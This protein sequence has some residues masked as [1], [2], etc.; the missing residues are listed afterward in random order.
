MVYLRKRR[1]KQAPEAGI[2]PGRRRRR[3]G[4]AERTG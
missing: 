3:A 1:W 4:L 2:R